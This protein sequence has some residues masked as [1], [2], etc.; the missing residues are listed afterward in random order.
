MPASAVTVVTGASTGIGRA[1]AERQ[2]RAGDNVWALVRDPAGCADLA[3]LAKDEHLDLRIVQADVADDGSVDTAFDTVLG[4]S[5]H[6]D[7]LV[8]NAGLFYGSTLEA[9]SLDEIRAMFEVNYFGALRCIRRVLPGMREA[10]GGVIAAVTSQ[11][12]QAIFPTWTAYAGSKSAL[13]GSLESIAMEVAGFG[14]R[15]AIVQPGITLTAM[16][17]KITPRTNPEAYAHMLDRYRTLI[18]ADRTESMAPDD[19]ALAIQQVLD[20]PASPFRTRVGTDAVRNIAL[21]ESVTDEQWVGLFGVGTDEEF[22]AQWMRMSG[23][24]DP[25]VLLDE[26]LADPR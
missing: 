8:N 22:Y 17:G 15:V 10:G 11:S 26:S 21:R 5:G 4:E 13:E 2:A 23:L 12:S 7:R 24:P 16:R 14:I 25:R 18:A 19:V 6:V 20:D 1:V 3:S 9:N